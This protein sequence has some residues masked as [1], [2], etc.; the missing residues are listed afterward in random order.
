VCSPGEAIKSDF[1]H[2]KPY[3]GSNGWKRQYPA[4]II[5]LDVMLCDF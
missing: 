5:A 1:G 3:L 2:A 4:G